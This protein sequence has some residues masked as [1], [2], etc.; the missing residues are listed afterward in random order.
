MATSSRRGKGR[1]TGKGQ[2]APQQDPVPHETP[3]IQIAADDPKLR[4]IK[5]RTSYNFIPDQK[6]HRDDHPILKFEEDSPEWDKFEKLKDTEL[7]QHRVIDWK[8]LEEIGLEQEV[9]ELLGQ[10]L[11]YAMNCIEPQYEELVLEFHSTWV[12]KEGKFEQGTTVSFSF[13]RQVYEMNV[14][15]FAVVSGLYTEEEVRR[16]ELATYLRGAYSECR[17]CSV[18]KAELNKFWNMISNREFGQTNLITSVRNPVYRYV[19]KILSMTLMGRKS[20]ENKANWLELFILMCRILLAEVGWEVLE[21]GWIWAPTLPGLQQ[22]WEC[23]T[24]IF[25]NFYTGGPKT[26]VFGMEELQKAGIV[27]W[28]A[29]YGWEPIKEGPHVQ[30]PQRRPAEVVVTQTEPTLTQQPPQAPEQPVRQVH[31]RHPLP[32]PL[33]LES[34]SGYVEQRFDRLEQMIE[35]LKKGQSRQDDVLRY[36]MTVQSM[37]IPDYI[38]PGQEGQAGVGA[39]ADPEPPFQVFE[40]SSHNSDSGAAGQQ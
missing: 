2:T 5:Y 17:D 3:I 39:Q 25:P 7:L 16:P 30:V 4:K 13:G 10:R 26:V 1:K 12:H 9:R 35:A 22:I 40:E 8:W 6:T 15:R 11:I 28:Q 29:P 32:E 27:S 37:R 21:L 36:M 14:P 38:R 19:L 20:G 34:F 24:H 18:G 31:R 23:L 33:T